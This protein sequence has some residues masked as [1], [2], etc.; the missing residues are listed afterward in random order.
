[1]RLTY[2]WNLVSIAIYFCGLVLLPQLVL[3]VNAAAVE[4]NGSMARE[5]LNHSATSCSTT[6]GYCYCSTHTHTHTLMPVVLEVA[7]VV[8]SHFIAYWFLEWS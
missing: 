6:T 7:L 1:M 5:L 3:V 4:W 2:L 8:L